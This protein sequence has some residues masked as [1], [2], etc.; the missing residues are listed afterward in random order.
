[1]SEIMKTKKYFLQIVSD[2]LNGRQVDK[3]IDIDYGKVLNLAKKNAVKT[4]V[5]S[6]LSPLSVLDEKQTEKLSKSYKFEIFRNSQQEAEIELL[7]KEFSENKIEFMFLKGTHLKG[8]YPSPEL[9]YM[10]DID[11]LVKKECIDRA[12][13]ILESHGFNQTHNNSKD[14]IFMKPPCLTIELHHSVFDENFMLFDY[15]KDVW[16]RAERVS[17]FEYK[18]PIN[19]LYVYVLA[20]LCEHYLVAGSCFR[21]CIDLYLLE[22]NCSLD[23]EY[24]NTQFN[25]MNISKFADNIR[26]LYSCMFDFNEPT[27][28]IAMMEN[29]IVFGAPVKNADMAAQNATSKNSHFRDS[30]KTI[31]PNLKGMKLRFPILEKFPFLLPICWIIRIVHFTF[32]CDKAVKNK[33]KNVFYHSKKDDNIMGEIFK[34]SG[35]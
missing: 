14:I 25:E 32:A 10:V 6:A 22:K 15:Y 13:K 11:V 34:K 33:R 26:K 8:L 30:L 16:S 3:S 20:H 24:I 9:R 35:L 27:E 23:F 4:I 5:F 12:K 31:F 21:P 2:V 1:M 29:Y 18:M 19:D 7:R 28:E 17:N